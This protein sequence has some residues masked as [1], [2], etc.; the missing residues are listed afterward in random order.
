MAVSNTQIVFDDLYR[1]FTDLAIVVGIIVFALM[2]YLIVRYRDR[3]SSQDPEDTPRLGRIPIGRGHGRNVLVTVTL[4][5]ILLAVL[6]FTSFAA[7]DVLFPASEPAAT[8]CY[9]VPAYNQT[10]AAGQ[11]CPRLEASGHQFYWTFSYPRPNGTIH[12]DVG[13]FRV[14]V[15]S[16]IVL[17]VTSNDVFHDFGIIEF[18]IKTDAIPGRTN[19]IWFVPYHAG[20][21]TIQCFELCGTGHYY[22][23]ATLDVM[24]VPAFL[25]WYNS[26]GLTK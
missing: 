10:Q 7:V 17:D 6:I 25:S 21:Y 8:W 3:R 5:T 22:M 18:K 1:I 11:S 13:M 4:S 16:T 20:N 14:P 12:Q 15:N 9:G 19:T 26:T 23:T 2:V 24:S